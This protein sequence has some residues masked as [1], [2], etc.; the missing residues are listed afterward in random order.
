MTAGGRGTLGDKQINK[1]IHSPC[2]TR[3]YGRRGE[4]AVKKERRT[5][6]ANHNRGH[7]LQSFRHSIISA[8]M[9]RPI[10]VLIGNLNLRHNIIA[11]LFAGLLFPKLINKSHNLNKGLS[12]LAVI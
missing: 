4:R 8:I 12:G 6:L 2:N 3:G 10:V 7:T 5:A 9:H 11:S 1:A